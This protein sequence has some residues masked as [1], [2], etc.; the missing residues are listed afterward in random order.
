[1]NTSANTLQLILVRHAEADGAS[2]RCIGHTDLPLSEAGRAS[3]EMLCSSK[4]EFAQA[5]AARVQDTVLL[6]SDLIRARETAA[7]IGTTF[8]IPVSRDARLRE[9]SFGAWDGATWQHLEA[10]DGERLG[11]WMEQWQTA[12]PPEGESVADVLQRVDAVLAELRR[13]PQGLVIVVAHAGWIRLALCRMRDISSDRMFDLEVPY[14]APIVCR[15]DR[16]TGRSVL[17]Q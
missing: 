16:E 11:A 14:A 6:S 7:R 15:V 1:M 13:L 2:G 12:A 5:L 3:L 4:G 8:N 10:T 9:M 17:V